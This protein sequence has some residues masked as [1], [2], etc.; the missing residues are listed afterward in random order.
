[1]VDT[2]DDVTLAEGEPLT[3][4]ELSLSPP[5]LRGLADAGF[6]QPSPIQ[7]HAIPLG[8][9][10]V[11]VIAQAKSGTGKTLVFVV[12]ALELVQP[13]QPAP[14]VLLVA[15]TRE[16]AQQTRDVCRILGAHIAGLSC[17]AFVGGTSIKIDAGHA[18]SCLVACGTPGRLVGLLLTE[19]LIASRVRLLV[20]DE[21][22]KLCDEGFESQMRYLLTALPER[23]QTLAFSATYPPELLR[24]L[25]Q[26][27]RSP[28]LVS[29]LPGVSDKF[30][31]ASARSVAGSSTGAERGKCMRRDDEESSDPLGLL[32]RRIEFGAQLADLQTAESQLVGGAALK[33]VQQHYQIV[34]PAP[35]AR[36]SS[37]HQRK[38]GASGL[39][40]AK[41]SEAVRLLSTLCFHQAILFCNQP[42]QALQ[43]AEALESAG[44][45][46][47]LISGSLPQAERTAAVRRMRAFH[48]RVLVAT[49][50]LARGVDFGRVTLVIHHSLPRDLPT[51]LHRVGRTGRYGTQGV[52]VLL[53]EESELQIAQILLAPLAVQVSPLLAVLPDLAHSEHQPCSPPQDSAGAGDVRVLRCEADGNATARQDDADDGGTAQGVAHARTPRS[54]TRNPSGP[55]QEDLTQPTPP[56]GEPTYQ[57]LPHPSQ[58]PSLVASLPCPGLLQ[59]GH[60]HAIEKARERGRQRGLERARQRARERF[61]MLFEE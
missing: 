18:S 21:A 55:A 3:F 61:G 53:L 48:V 38:M 10:G 22:D 54:A 60:A 23:K 51:Y 49:D 26:S 15:P 56:D 39:P 35:T 31:C 45:P 11:D 36:S 42:E 34:P 13:S 14:Q 7:A 52:S 25:K 8:R 59:G 4:D 37:G 30:N 47:A 33:N 19:A 43:L 40:D 32:E 6:T 57:R 50:L 41:Q 29:L 2:G 12:I 24:D 27:M 20:L 16:I 17:H 9:L 28:I 58:N 46:S 5:I 44:F 1:M